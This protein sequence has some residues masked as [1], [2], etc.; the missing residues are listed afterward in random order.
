MKSKNFIIS[1]ITGSLSALGTISQIFSS[2]NP[3]LIV[4]LCVLTFLFLYLAVLIFFKRKLIAGQCEEVGINNIVQQKYTT[5]KNYKKTIERLKTATEIR[6]FHTTGQKFFHANETAIK[7]AICNNDA[8]VHV[9][10]GKKGS[11]FLSDVSVLEVNARDYKNR[12]IRTEKQ[13]IHTEITD[14]ENLL[15]G[16]MDMNDNPM[17]SIK[18]GY[19]ETEF[20]MSM[21]LTKDNKG[22]EWGWITLTLPPAKARNSISFEIEGK[23][24]KEDDNIYNQC[25]THFDAIWKKVTNFA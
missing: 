22:N 11:K 3:F 2:G 16:L 5:D 7:D 23:N 20:R 10:I 6:I 17:G 9:L 19:V 4:F 12:Q 18:I 13:D 21:T 25:V 1:L 24:Q 14:V 8:K 15:K